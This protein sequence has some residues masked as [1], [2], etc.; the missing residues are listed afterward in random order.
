MHMTYPGDVRQ[1]WTTYEALL[2]FFKIP[3]VGILPTRKLAETFLYT[4]GHYQILL[5]VGHMPSC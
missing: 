5:E 2:K 1:G 4:R 3:A